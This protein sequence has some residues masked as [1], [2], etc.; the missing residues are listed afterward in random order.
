MKKP[1]QILL[2]DDNPDDR[3]LIIRQLKKEFADVDIVQVKDAASLQEALEGQEIDVAITDYQLRWSDGLSVLRRIKSQRPACPT[4]MFTATGSE[5]IAVEAMKAGLDDYVLKSPKHFSRLRSAVRTAMERADAHRKVTQLENRLQRLLER[6]KVG[7]FRSTP[8]GRLIEANPS[9]LQILGLDSLQQ[10]NLI[11]LADFYPS[12]HDREQFINTVLKQGFV[13]DQEVQLKRKDGTLIWVSLTEAVDRRGKNEIYLEGIMEDIT[14]RKQGELALKQSEERYRSLVELSPIPMG[15]HHNGILLYA[16]PA[17]VKLL[18]AKS[19]QDLI[20]KPVLDFV[21]PDYKEIATQR[22]QQLYQQRQQTTLIEEKLVTLD[23]RVIDAEVM[24]IPIP[25]EGKEAVQVILRDITEHKRTQNELKR[26]EEKFR[27]LIE[28]AADMITLLDEQGKILFESPSV[29]ATLGYTPEELLGKSAIEF[30]HPE[31]LPKIRKVLQNFINTPNKK[32]PYLEIRIRHKNG[33]WCTIEAVGKNLLNAPAIH[34]IVINSRDITDRKKLEEQLY[35]S[36]KMEAIGRLAGGIAHDFNNLLTAIIGY[37][38]F[39][40]QSLN[41]RDPMREDAAEI[42]KAAEHAASLTRQL[43][44][45]SRKQILKPKIINLNTIIR[46]MGKMLSRIIGE[47]IEL[48]T[49]LSPDLASVKADPAQIEQVILNLAIN[50]RDAMPK[51]GK[52]IIETRNATLD[53]EYINTHNAVI[54]GPYVLL[55]MS[56]NGVGMDQDTQDKIFEPFFTTK[57]IGKGTGLGLAT[58]YGVVKQSG[59]YIWVYSEPGHGTTFKIYLPR[60]EEAEQEVEPEKPAVVSLQGTETIL[61]VEDE[62]LLRELARRVLARHGYTVLDASNGGEALLICEKHQGPIHLLLTDVVL[63][64]MNGRELADR[65][66]RLRP[67]MKVIYMSGYTN[68]AILENGLL[69]METHFIQKPF[70][71]DFLAQKVREVLNKKDNG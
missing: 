40:L 3:T 29:Y 23:G 13:Y 30:V 1:L 43:L 11:N 54:P 52:L 16:N 50:S 48:V 36:Q 67:Q 64:R 62:E 27:L 42:K 59:G 6:L 46:D 24:G 65:L 19:E 56:D 5:E 44:A 28:N 32:T 47:D 35:Q 12:S 39:M 26:S 34:A 70:T 68:D 37:G 71:A 18:G 8:D 51:G 15:V 55:V 22:V 20:G 61:V 38:D 45:F 17:A 41:P 21:H 53:E 69:S 4:I 9:C 60:A 14:Q 49:Q 33:T 58:V 63:P 31:D 7:V 57:E 25:Y 10:A 66:L 2:I